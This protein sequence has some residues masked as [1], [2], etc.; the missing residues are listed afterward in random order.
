MLESKEYKFNSLLEAV[1]KFIEFKEI[2]NS[3]TKLSFQ[4]INEELNIY[5]VAATR[6]KNVIALTD[7]NLAYNYNENE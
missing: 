6:A 1:E 3:K 4:R 7:L 5:Y 2:L